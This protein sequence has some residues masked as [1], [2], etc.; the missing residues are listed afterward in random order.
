MPVTWN[1]SDKGPNLTLSGGDLT[2]T[3]A[4]GFYDQFVR[5]TD[6]KTTGKWV[7]S[8]VMNT[9]DFTE[10]VG[11][12]NS[13]QDLTDDFLPLANA[14]ITLRD[15]NTWSYNGTAPGTTTQFWASSTE[16]MIAVDADTREVWMSS[17]GGTTWYGS[18]AG[19]PAAGTN[20]QA[21]GFTGAIFPCVTTSDGRSWVGRF[22]DAD[23]VG[24][25]P[26]GFSAWDSVT[27][28]DPEYNDAS[29]GIAE[30]MHFAATNFARLYS[31][32]SQADQN[33]ISSTETPRAVDDTGWAYLNAVAQHFA[34]PWHT[35]YDTTEVFFPE[36]PVGTDVNA[37]VNQTLDLVT[38]VE[39]AAVVVSASATQTLD[40]L[41][42]AETVGVVVSAS[43]AQTLGLVQQ[44]ANVSSS[45]NASVSQTLGLAQQTATA[46]VRVS[47]SAAQT[48]PLLTVAETAAIV[49]SAS[50]AQTLGLVQQTANVTVSTPRTVSVDQTLAL[51][52]QTSVGAVQVA[53]LGNV[54]LPVLSQVATAVG[55]TWRDVTTADGIWSDT[56][57]ASGI[58]IPRDPAS[59][60]WS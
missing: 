46:A 58:W 3:A 17:D 6:S 29:A 35:A 55:P 18:A 1:P 54:T 7:F 45:T 2:V 11:V 12:C 26:S 40:L 36:D 23:I 60:S 43:V 24:T 57:D 19:S 33:T 38:A 48:L 31:Y 25:I 22:T 21:V 28:E 44:T 4:A 27:V 50:V 8:A 9:A 52:T 30:Q 37:S 47:A 59:G 53:V 13:T 51:L 32:L 39:T 34:L 5:A 20:G 56:T 49:V 41:T 42:V 15:R 14:I 10:G 16:I